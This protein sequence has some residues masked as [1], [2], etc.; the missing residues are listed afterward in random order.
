M[1]AAIP[2][3]PVLVV[4]AGAGR[5]VLHRALACPELKRWQAFEARDVEHAR[6]LLQHDACEVVLIDEGEC[7][8]N[9]VESLSRLASRH[10]VP[11][12]ILGGSGEAETPDA[13]Q[14]LPRDLAFGWPVLLNEALGAALRERVLWRCARRADAELR[15]CRRQIG[16]LLGVL[17]EAAPTNAHAQWFTQRTMLERLEEEVARARRYH[18]PVSVA[19]G[20]MPAPP[21]EDSPAGSPGPRAWLVDRIVSGKRRSDIAGQYGPHGFM[22]IMP[23]TPADG[24]AVCCRRLR[25]FV[26]QPPAIAPERPSSSPVRACFGIASHPEEKGPAALLA[27]AEQCL[28]KAESEGADRVVLA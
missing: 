17:W 18:A 11:V 5:A 16:Q 25:D 27:R 10:G 22:L 26:D 23:N 4:S 6:F 21:E 28:E 3:D 7:N 1:V 19:V 15:D 13:A 24:A 8:H 20:G 9:D 12:V 2:Y 14:R